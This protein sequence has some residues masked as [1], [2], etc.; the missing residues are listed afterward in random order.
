MCLSVC[1]R[2]G[3]DVGVADVS[4][5]QGASADMGVGG[6]DAVSE[7]QA[8]YP[9]SDL[10]HITQ[11]L[12]CPLFT[13]PI[14]WF[15]QDLVPDAPPTND[16]AS[17]C[18]G[19]HGDVCDDGDVTGSETSAEVPA[20]TQAVAQLIT[21]LATDLNFYEAPRVLDASELFNEQED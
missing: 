1:W 4:A 20:H 13:K 8:W 7:L 21:E 12:Y 10:V 11:T 18:T 9:S 14:E 15:L 17:N 19:D 2:V 5:G 3:V 6:E 16:T